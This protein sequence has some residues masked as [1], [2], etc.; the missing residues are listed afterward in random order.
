MRDTISTWAYMLFIACMQ[1]FPSKLFE[2]VSK[3][4]WYQAM[5]EK[6]VDSLLL[7][8]P[9][10][11]LEA[12]C[13]TGYVCHYIHTCGYDAIGIDASPSMILEAKKNFHHHDFR[14]ENALKTSFKSH[15]FDLVMSASLIN[16]VDAPEDLIYESA[17]LC[18]MSGC[19]SYLFPVDT[20]SAHQIDAF[21]KTH[22]FSNFSKAVLKFWLTFGRKLSIN[23]VLDILDDNGFGYYQIDNFLDGMVVAI[24]A[25]KVTL[26]HN[27]S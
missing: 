1:L 21:I 5:L 13:A 9:K 26:S 14:V 22:S 2:M 12:G 20:I 16:I 19:V 6:W 23:D 18:K 8:H 17:R 4:D 10:A 7:S 15:S 11:I 3:V 27:L 24:R 25:S